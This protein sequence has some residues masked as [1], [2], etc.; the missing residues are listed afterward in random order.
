MTKKDFNLRAIKALAFD[1]DGTLL[2]PDKSLSGRTLRAI[3]SCMSRGIRIILATG[4]AVNS[5]EVYREY[6]GAEG[7]QVYYNGAEVID[8]PR[9]RL[10]HAQFVDPGPILFCLGLAREK[11]LYF[12]VYFPAKTGTPAG[13]GEL[14]MTERLTAESE[15]YRNNSGFQPVAGNVEEAIGGSGLP[16]LIKG[17]FITGEEHHGEIRARLKEKYGNSVYVVRSSPIYLEILASGVSKG[18]GLLR[19]LEYLGLAGE[20]ALAF[21]DEENDLPMFSVAGFSAAPANAKQAVHDAAAF[22][23]PSNAD[24]GVA[25]FLEERFGRRGG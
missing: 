11:G 4:R 13:R 16:G 24:D 5:G 22:R 1:L 9:G 2:R 25:C 15:F 6:I 7:P 20:E 23:I 14:L 19:A 18:A 10:I 17:M 21:G 3:R 12:Q 8:M